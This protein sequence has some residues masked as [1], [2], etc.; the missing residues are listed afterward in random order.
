MLFYK[1]WI[2]TRVRFFTGLVAVALVCT[3]YLE[4]HAWLAQMWTRDLQNPHGYHFPWMPLAIRE[5]GWYL[6]HFLYENYLQQVWSLFAVLFAF[7]GLAREKNIGNALFSLGLPVSRRR[8]LFSRLGIAVLESVA[9][10]LFAVVYV[11]AGSHVIHQTCPM[12][13]M[14]S[15]SLLMVAAGIVLIAFGNFCYSLFPGGYLSLLATLVLLGAPYL[16]LQT[17]MQNMRSAGRSTWFKAFDIA[18][19]M[20][21]PWQLTWASTPWL[22]LCISWALTLLFLVTAVMHGDHLDY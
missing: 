1:A 18:H 4:Q 6:W 15:H 13:E 21:G 22:A 9:L 3:F 16:L 10:S 17:Y 5:Y 12:G 7:G 20:A 2:E 14:L 19:A 11:A 8:W